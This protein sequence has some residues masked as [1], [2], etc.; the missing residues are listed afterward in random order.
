MSDIPE[1]LSELADDGYVGLNMD[2]RLLVS[3]ACI[4]IRSAEQHIEKLEAQ[5]ERE[6]I[7]PYHQQ[8]DLP[9]LDNKG[10]TTSGKEQTE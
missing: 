9:D 6:G 1:R 5:F 7:I 10:V 2:Q 3:R 8:G 4:H